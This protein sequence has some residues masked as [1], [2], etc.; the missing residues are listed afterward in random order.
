MGKDGVKGPSQAPAPRRLV[1]ANHSKHFPDAS[2]STEPNTSFLPSEGADPSSS[3][4]SLR[5]PGPLGLFQ[6]DQGVAFLPPEPS[7]PAIHGVAGRVW[8]REVDGH[9]CPL[10]LPGG[11]PEGRGL[12][13]ST[14]CQ[15]L[16][17]SLRQKRSTLPSGR[18]RRQ[19]LEERLSAVGGGGWEA[20]VS[21][22]SPLGRAVLQS[23]SPRCRAPGGQ[24]GL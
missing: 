23:A 14:G 9:S 10:T 11:G 5:A 21:L 16:P 4:C 18:E 7:L 19:G 12:R 13:V 15:G 20:L 6:G 24:C 22:I 2:R 1:R 17:G 8:A 3:P